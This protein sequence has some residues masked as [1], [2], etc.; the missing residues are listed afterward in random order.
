MTITEN[1]LFQAMQLLRIRNIKFFPDSEMVTPCVLIER[2]SEENR[3]IDCGKGENLNNAF[4]SALFESFERY[5]AEHFSTYEYYESSV[6]LEKHINLC[7]PSTLYPFNPMSKIADTK[8]LFWSKGYDLLN[9]E[10]CYVPTECIAFPS[11]SEFSFIS[12]IGLASGQTYIEAVNH[13]IYEAIEHDTLTTCLI[14]KQI[15]KRLKITNE[16]ILAQLAIFSNKNIDIEI[17]YLENIYG[18]PCVITLMRNAPHFENNNIAGMGC[19]LNLDIAI[20]RSITECQ[21]SYDFWYDKYLK[22]DF[23]EKEIVHPPLELNE[24]FL[25][26]KDELEIDCN[27]IIFESYEEELEYIL[28][29]L[30]E[31][32]TRL[33]CIDITNKNLLIPT[34]KVVI[35]DFLET[36]E[37]DY[38]RLKGKLLSDALENRSDMR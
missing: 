8:K 30:K 15:G 35:P 10:N 6:N 12:T 16:K 21:Q 3:I 36:I 32:I 34:V 33:I 19:N 1:T 18:I 4:Y 38:I 31:Y 22:G 29:K 28:N 2:G 20:M 5:S 11:K 14:T 17:R 37:S 24:E 26:N 23:E 27:K 13:A 7:S 25:L 9:K